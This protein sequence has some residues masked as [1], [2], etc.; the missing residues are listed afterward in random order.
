MAADLDEQPAEP[1]PIVQIDETLSAQKAAKGSRRI[2]ASRTTSRQRWRDQN[3]SVRSWRSLPDPFHIGPMPVHRQ[4]AGAALDVGDPDGAKIPDIDTH[5]HRVARAPPAAVDVTVLSRH[6]DTK[7]T[8]KRP[9]T[10]L[11][12]SHACVR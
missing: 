9:E 10:R 2:S 8:V 4:L 11:I 6:S 1:F 5:I 3:T 7:N 12:H